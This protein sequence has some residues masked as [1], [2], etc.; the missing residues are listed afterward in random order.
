[1]AQVIDLDGSPDPVANA[2]AETV[3][4]LKNR[5]RAKNQQPPPKPLKDLPSRPGK[6]IGSLSRVDIY[7]EP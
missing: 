7:D 1:M 2:I 4:N 3:V 5:Y 6:V